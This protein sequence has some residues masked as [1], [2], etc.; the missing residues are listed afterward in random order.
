MEKHTNHLINETSPYLLQ[1][2]HNPVNWYP[3]GEEALALA[4][5]EHKLIIVSIGYAACHWCHV[6][7]HES[8]EDTTVANLMNKYYIAIKVDREE[9]PDVDQVYMDAAHIMTGRGGWPLNVIALPDGRPIYAGTYFPKEQWLKVLQGVQEF[10]QKTPE[11]ALEQAMQVASGVSKMNIVPKASVTDFTREVLTAAARDWVQAMDMQ[12]GGRRG[13]MK[14]PMPASY[15][16]LLN[17]A[18]V[19]HDG[20]ATGAVTLT[21]DKMAMGGIYD[22]LGGGF[23][24]YSVDPYWHVPHFEKMLYDNAQLITLYS[25][26]YKLTKNPFYKQVVEETIAFCQRELG[27]PEGGFYAS[28]DADSEGEEGKF[29][30]W[31]AAE[32]DEILGAEG[33][34]FKRYYGVTR[35]GNWEGGKNVLKITGDVKKLAGEFGL[36]EEEITGYIKTAREK[37]LAVREKRI[38][39][40]LDDKI[41]TSWNGLMISGLAHAYEALATEACRQRAVALGNFIYE[42]MWTGKNLYRNRK[43]GQSTINGFLDD[44]AFTIM[45]FIDLYRITFDQQW[46]SRANELTRVANKEFFDDQSGMYR[47]KSAKDD[48]LYVKKIVVEDNVIPAGNS[49]MANN[50]FHL[51]HLLYDEAYLARSRTMLAAATEAMQQYAAFYYGWFNL[52]QLHLVE[53]FEVVIMGDDYDPVRQQL[54]Q[55]FLPATL[56]LGGDKEGELALL[57]DKRV[58]GKTLIYVCVNKTCQLPVDEAGQA[59]AQMQELREN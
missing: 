3:W 5:K 54:A 29:Y 40:G 55:E 35:Q 15:L 31:A 50:L 14:F 39:P 56:L 33:E 18:V 38:R 13:N 19:N 12:E 6:M 41:L 51:G 7:E 10:Y 20:Q 43:N 44:Y 57:K 46:L 21:L 23:S 59:L 45:G 42:K 16:A 58:P 2:A 27:A 48:P 4:K 30:V 25:E 8:F 37:L 28:L 36:T 52:Y 17:Y 1:H 9:R 49:A 22:Q 11:K 53:P 47:F 26:A 24:R 32:I 34:I